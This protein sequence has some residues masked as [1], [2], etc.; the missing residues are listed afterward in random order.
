MIVQIVGYWIIGLPLGYWL[1][2]RRHYGAVGLWLGLCAG[3]IVAGLALTTVW[4]RT[5]RK[6]MTLDSGAK[7]QHSIL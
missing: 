3:L 5:T 2:F 6:L 4:H 7:H 1:G